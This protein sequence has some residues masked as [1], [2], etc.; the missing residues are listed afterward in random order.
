MGLAGAGDLGG[1][2]DFGGAGE[3]LCPTSPSPL[4][5]YRMLWARVGCMYLWVADG[6]G[7]F[8]FSTC[9]WLPILS[10]FFE[11]FSVSS[12][13]DRGAVVLLCFKVFLSDFVVFGWGLNDRIEVW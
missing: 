2:G 11:L 6:V 1:A 4:N 3:T 7:V 9:S 10:V 8:L 13:V 12:L 5:P